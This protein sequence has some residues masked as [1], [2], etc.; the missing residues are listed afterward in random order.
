MFRRSVAK[1]AIT[2]YSF[3]ILPPKAPLKASPLLLAEGRLLQLSDGRLYGVIPP[4]REPNQPRFTYKRT[5]LKDCIWRQDSEAAFKRTGQADKDAVKILIS[6]DPEYFSV[7]HGEVFEGIGWT[8]DIGPELQGSYIVHGEIDYQFPVG[9]FE[10][11]STEEGGIPTAE[12]LRS[13]I[14]PF[15]QK[16]NWRKPKE[17]VERFV[18]SRNLW[19]MEVRG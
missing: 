3:Y 8:V 18:G 11:G 15:E 7:Q 14:E 2:V 17:I 19:H 9:T 4:A 16:Y 13:Y 1:D 12:Y 5:V 10:P 6:F